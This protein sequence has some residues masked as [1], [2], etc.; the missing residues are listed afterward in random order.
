MLLADGAAV[1]AIVTQGEEM[2]S[3][4]AQNVFQI[5]FVVPDIHKG[6]AF[7]K[8]KLG[9]PEFLFLENPGLETYLGQPAPLTVRLAFGWCGNTQIELIQPIAGVS[10]Y[11]K[12]L[13]HNPQGGMHHYCTEVDNYA[14]GVKDME[15]C[16]FPLVQSGRHNE[17]RFAYF[18]TTGMIGALTEIVYLQPE[19]KAFMQ[20]LKHKSK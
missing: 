9:V 2:A 7:F 1:A 6:M 20:T 17:T 14:Q 8:D 19:E 18:D 4:L 10:T 16:G 15:S 3:T 12:F 5:G 13:E 11:S